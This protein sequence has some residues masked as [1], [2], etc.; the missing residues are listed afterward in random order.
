[1][2]RTFIKNSRGRQNQVAVPKTVKTRTFLDE[3]YQNTKGNK[4]KPSKSYATTVQQ[5]KR[6]RRATSTPIE[7]S[8]SSSDAEDEASE[9]D[10]DS[11]EDEPLDQAPSATPF[12]GEAGHQYRSNHF[13]DAVS[14]AGS[15]G[16]MFDANFQFE[17]GDP[18]FFP[19]N[20][21]SKVN[22][23]SDDN[24]D[25]A[26][27]AVDD[28][29]DSDEE[30]AEAYEEQQLLSML[31]DHEVGEGEFLNQIDGLSEYGFGNDS[32]A[33]AQLLPSSGSDTEPAHQRH[34]R[35]DIDPAPPM[36]PLISS[37]TIS[38]ALLP[39]ALPDSGGV[40]GGPASASAEVPEESSE[41]EAYDCRLL[42]HSGLLVLI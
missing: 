13:D 33:T 22:V 4:N 31:S 34:V 27:K 17:N 40:F 12:I 41:E 14:E 38:R 26:Y 19:L 21:E 5:L 20:D 9:D 11:D 36:F 32:D 16:S 29:S 18:D 30:D 2:P 39:S 25:D 10:E 24:D 15:I 35:F 8:A 7:S 23:D 1:M 6:K 28:I 37:P 42:Q 3:S